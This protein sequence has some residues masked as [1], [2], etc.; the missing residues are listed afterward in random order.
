MPEERLGEKTPVRVAERRALHGV[1]DRM[2]PENNLRYELSHILHK[3]RKY[4]AYRGVSRLEVVRGNRVARVT[5]AFGGGDLYFRE[6]AEIRE[7]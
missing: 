7:E 3:S 6:R 1:R 5:G 4:R 2:G